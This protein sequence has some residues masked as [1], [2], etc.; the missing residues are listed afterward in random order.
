M[1]TA[2]FWEFIHGSPVKITVRQGQRLHHS[3]GAPT[4]EGYHAEAHVWE[5]DGYQV[6]CEYTTQSRDCDG[7]HSFYSDTVCPV[8]FLAAGYREEND[9]AIAY[10]QWHRVGSSQRDQ[11]AEM[12]GY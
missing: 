10:P 1:R 8:G 2:R 11:F 12:M 4:D 5:L 7:R 3:S 9:P 6:R